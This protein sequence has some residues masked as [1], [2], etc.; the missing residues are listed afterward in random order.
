MRTPIAL[1]WNRQLSQKSVVPRYG[2]GSVGS[3][4][5]GFVPVLLTTVGPQD[6]ATYRYIIG[7]SHVKSPRREDHPSRYQ[8]R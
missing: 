1:H 7:T 2:D 3:F 4:T 8:T 6:G 5:R